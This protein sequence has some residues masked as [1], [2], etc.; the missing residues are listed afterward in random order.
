MSKRK[1]VALIPLRG[2]SKSIHKKN[3]KKIAGKPLC[4]WILEAVHTVSEIDDVYVSTEDEE[5]MQE[6]K[7]LGLGTKIIKRPPEF[8]TDEAST[9][10]VMM[11]FSQEVDFDIL[12]TLQATSPLTTSED[13]SRGLDLFFSK[14]FDSLLTGVRV[15]SLFWTIEAKPVNYDFKKRPRR[16]EMKGWFKENGAF[17]ITTRKLL[18]STGFRLGGNICILEMAPETITDIDEPEDWQLVE[19]ILIHKK[20]GKLKNLLNNIRLLAIDV[21]GTLTDAGMY[22]SNQ[23]E[24]LKKFN[25]RD[26]KGIELLRRQ[27]IE[28][29][30]ITSEDSEIVKARGKK[31]QLKH[32]FCGIQDKQPVLKNLC[33]ELGISFMNVAFIGDDLNDLS[34]ITDVGFSACPVDAIAVIK[35]QVDYICKEKGGRGAVRELCDL[36]LAQISPGVQ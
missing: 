9:E 31:L 29:V 25:T 5:I 10:S 30:I 4:A 26:A 16:Q 21:D 13:I 8:A 11:H 27:G 20:I 33:S 34:C 12:V 7:S 1:I 15:K 17:Y 35:N 18:I 3:I 6:V 24:L 14:N 36:I 2:G 32:V 22:Y 19:R 28:T 23:G